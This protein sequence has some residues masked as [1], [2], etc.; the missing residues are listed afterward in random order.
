MWK[1]ALCVLL[2]VTYP[3]DNYAK[4]VKQIEADENKVIGI[5]TA[6]GY[7]TIIELSSKPISA[8][9]GDQDAFKL[10][11]VG[12]SITVKPLIPGAK[13]NLF[14]FTEY[15]RFNCTLRTTAP[16][17]VDYI[18][19]LRRRVESNAIVP[20]NTADRTPKI[21]SQAINRF[22]IFDGYR[23]KVVSLDRIEETTQSRA[24]TVISIELSSLRKNYSFSGAALGVKQ[25]GK[26]VTIE[27][28]YLDALQIGPKLPIV[29]GKIVLLEGEF[30]RNSPLSVIFAVSAQKSK[31]KA[32]RLE[33]LIGRSNEKRKY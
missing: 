27:S 33:V 30:R 7:S 26:F 15:D 16:G 24:A 13:S 22:S 19:K 5:N 10:E 32:R 14:I 29:R 28:L 9:L 20:I 8:V 21:A 1:K 2:C 6:L 11:Y 18:V 17:E 3:V 23:L 25:G 4:T 31:S 12:N